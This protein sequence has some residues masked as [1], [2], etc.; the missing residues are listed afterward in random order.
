MANAA[1][2]L[3]GILR[4]IIRKPRIV[5]FRISVNCSIYEKRGDQNANLIRKGIQK[6][7]S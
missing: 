5:R 2:I 6:I 1:K 7:K 4:W 3:M